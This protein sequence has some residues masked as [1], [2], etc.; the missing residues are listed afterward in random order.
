MSRRLRRFALIASAAMLLSVTSASPFTPAAAVP[1][2]ADPVIAAV[3]DIACQSFSQSDGE[4]ACRSDEVAAL[5]TQLA[6]D[7]FF[8]LGDLQYNN[9]K[10]EE[11][12]AGLR[13]AVRSPQADHDAGSRQPRVRDRGRAGLLRLLRGRRARPRGVLLLRSRR[14]ARRVA[15]LRH[16]PRRSGLRAGHAAVRLAGRRPRRERRRVHAR[17]PAP[18]RVRLAYLAAVRR[19]R[20]STAERRVGE[21]DVPRPVAVAGRRGS[22]RDAQRPQ[23]HLS[24]VGSSARRRSAGGG[25][26][27]AVHGRDRGALA[28]PAREEAAA[29]EPPRGAEQGVRR[30]ADDA[31][32]ATGTTTTGSG[33][34]RTRCSTTVGRSPAADACAPE[35]SRRARDPAPAET[36]RR[37]R[38]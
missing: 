3:G 38:P 5:I 29:R 20:R 14:V 1:P 12:L 28:V 32:R 34:P 7:R 19:P 24:P 31:A 8:A 16:L 10:L 11:F 21:R 4:G 33:S 17:L 25:R 18:S 26:D 27:P 9:G 30:V 22:G 13:P 23:P 15:E 2:P 36:E 35:S 6:P 37:G